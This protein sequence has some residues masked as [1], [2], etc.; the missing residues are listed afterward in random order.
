MQDESVICKGQVLSG[1]PVLLDACVK[2][3]LVVW[4]TVHFGVFQ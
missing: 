1:V 2:V 3:G 4:E